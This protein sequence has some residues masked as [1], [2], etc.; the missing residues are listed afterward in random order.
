MNRCKDCKHFMPGR[1]AADMGR[2]SSIN[3]QFGTKAVLLT[4]DESVW[5]MAEFGCVQFE[6]KGQA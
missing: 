3:H 2:C 6:P 1:E 4:I 5:V